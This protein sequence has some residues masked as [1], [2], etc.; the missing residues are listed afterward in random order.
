[1]VKYM[2]AA[3]MMVLSSALGEFWEELKKYGHLRGGGPS[4][5]DDGEVIILAIYLEGTMTGKPPE[6]IKG[7]RIKAEERPKAIGL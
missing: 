4:Q 3:Q 2:N 6:S 7:F 5:E 1:M